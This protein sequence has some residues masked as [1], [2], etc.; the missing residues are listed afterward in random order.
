MEM[1]CPISRQALFMLRSAFAL[2]IGSA[3]MMFEVRI[4]AAGTLVRTPGQVQTWRRV[5]QMPPAKQPGLMRPFLIG[6]GG[7][8]FA[9]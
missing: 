9:P 4:A 5:R 1:A 2:L 7:M 6:H 8:A 3:M